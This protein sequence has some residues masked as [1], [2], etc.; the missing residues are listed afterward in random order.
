MFKMRLLLLILDGEPHELSEARHYLTSAVPPQVLQRASER[1]L[2]TD[3][4]LEDILQDGIQAA[5][6]SVLWSMENKG[7]IYVARPNIERRVHMPKSTK[8]RDLWKHVVQITPEGK[9]ALL[10][11][12]QS[13]GMLVNTFWHDLRRGLIRANITIVQPNVEVEM[14]E[15]GVTS[16]EEPNEV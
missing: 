15:A 14:E 10:N 3:I 4:P 9:E 12:K 8:W 2:V 5:G 6:K 11:S 13:Y 7:Q 1:K 16:S